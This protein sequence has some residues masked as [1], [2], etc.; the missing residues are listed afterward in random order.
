MND[1]FFTSYY[2]QFEKA[3][4]CSSTG[5]SF[6][7]GDTRFCEMDSFVDSFMFDWTQKAELALEQIP[8]PDD[9]KKTGLINRFC[10][11][12]EFE[13]LY[14]QPKYNTYSTP[15]FTLLDIDNEQKRN[16]YANIFPKNRDGYFH[17]M[18]TLNP[19]LRTFFF[20]AIQTQNS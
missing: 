4:N 5:N 8:V 19:P 12:K 20:P 1:S 17:L 18:E 14:S 3:I 6:Y 2:T 7:L 13:Q 15:V 9:I 11:Y 16:K 10:T